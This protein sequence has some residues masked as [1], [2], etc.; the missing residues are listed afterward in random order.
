V[1]RA[2]SDESPI[3]LHQGRIRSKD[4]RARRIGQQDVA[5]AVDGDHAKSS[6]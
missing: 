2:A 6:A 1:L 4:F 5:A 3:A